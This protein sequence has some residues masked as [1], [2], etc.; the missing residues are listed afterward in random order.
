MLLV[1]LARQ[2]AGYILP[3]SGLSFPPAQPPSSG[4]TICSTRPILPIDQ[5]HP[6]T[7]DS[8][9]RALKRTRGG[10]HRC[11]LIPSGT[12]DT[13]HR[14]GRWP[15]I[16]R[17]LQDALRAFLK[18]TKTDDPRVDFYNIYK[19][20]ATEFDMSHI[21]KYD[22]VFNTTLIF[23]RR[24]PLP[25]VN[26]LTCARRG[27]YSLSSVR[28]L[29]SISIRSFSP[30]RTINLRPS[31]APSSSLSTRPPSPVR[32]PSCRLFKKA[33]RARSLSSRVSCT[34]AF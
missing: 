14:L 19:R 11:K 31:S 6:N 32:P 22:D 1:L 23:V 27:V 34:R 29:L 12:F 8:S 17:S 3:L 25:F 5:P 21:Q 28:F 2:L 33:H 9:W 16:R 18:P 20:E 7:C 15:L 30:I 24:S 13:L 26:H 4:I 10:L